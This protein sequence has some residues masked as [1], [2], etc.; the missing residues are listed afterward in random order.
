MEDGQ[1]KKSGSGMIIAIVV[2][3]ILVAGYIFLSKKGT[4]SQS[5]KLSVQTVPSSTTE[6]SNSMSNESAT[7]LSVSGTEFSFSPS[8]L[9][10]KVG[11][12]VKVTFTNTGKMPHN[13]VIDEI[14]GAKTAT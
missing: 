11:Q 8:V 2:V 3:L 14:A 6:S 12:P 1:P 10:L 7:E 4:S 5:T 13:F 9:S